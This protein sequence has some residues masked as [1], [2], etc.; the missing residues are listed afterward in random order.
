M[1]VI[2]GATRPEAQAAAVTSEVTL[3][4]RFF[5]FHSEV[6]AGGRPKEGFVG[7][8]VKSCCSS[9]LSVIAPS[10][11]LR[12]SSRVITCGVCRKVTALHPR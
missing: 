11:P 5:V 9:G 12:S 1:I 4:G 7:A 3:H 2:S 6:V 10:R 8:W